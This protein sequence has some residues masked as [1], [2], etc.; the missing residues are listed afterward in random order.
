MHCAHAMGTGLPLCRVQGG[1]ATEA[2]P[3]PAELT[4]QAQAR[5]LLFGAPSLPAGPEMCRRIRSEG[6]GT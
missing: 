4:R 2:T 3:E 5:R 6:A 1:R